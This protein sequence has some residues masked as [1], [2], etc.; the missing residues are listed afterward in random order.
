MI[1]KDFHRI[2]FLTFNICYINHTHIHT[3][4]THISSLLPIH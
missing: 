4:V 1:A 3:N 2:T